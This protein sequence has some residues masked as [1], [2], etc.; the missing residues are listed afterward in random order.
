[1]KKNIFKNKALYFT[2]TIIA[3]AFLTMAAGTDVHAAD[4][5]VLVITN[6]DMNSRS[7]GTS[8]SSNTTRIN[9]VSNF[10]VAPPRTVPRS[11]AIYN[12]PAVA[13][14]ITAQQIA[15]AAYFQGDNT[16]VG[17]R[18]KDINNQLVTIQTRTNR[19]AEKLRSLQAKGRGNSAEYFANI[20]TINT[21]LQTGTTPGNPRLVKRLASAQTNLDT[22]NNNVA[23]LNSLAVEIADTASKA[24]FLLDSARS[25]YTV[26]G[27]IEEDHARLARLEDEINGTIVIIERILNDVNDDITRTTAYLASEQRNLR[28]LSLAVSN[29]NLYGK[30]LANYP[31]SRANQS[32]L[33]QPASLG[34]APMM[35]PQS[36]FNAP[37]SIGAP[38]PLAKIRFDKPNVNYEQPIYVAVQNALQQYPDT[39]F[40]LIA[41]HPTSGNPAQVAIE[42]TRSRRN[43]ERVLRTLT[44][45]GIDLERIDLSYAPSNEA[46]SSEVH[47]FLR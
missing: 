1:M 10:Q 39:R 18:V 43:A 16:I 20:A 17:Q 11:S 14:P 28:T 38:K 30:S 24:S 44:Q 21:Q 42:S 15:G 6:K 31:F 8:G 12:R 35:A 41:V 22:L 36:T 32:S 19:L 5:P 37:S 45:M 2:T 4:K 26:S 34:A 29:G 40:E 27:A 47:I 3:G 23:Q 46:Q 25:T 9:S 13:P 7:F 33:L